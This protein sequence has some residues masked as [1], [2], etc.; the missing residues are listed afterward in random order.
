[1][2]E[3]MV[4]FT[5]AERFPCRLKFGLFFLRFVPMLVVTFLLMFMLVLLLIH[6]I[7]LGRPLPLVL[8]LVAALAAVLIALMKRRFDRTW[9]VAELELSAAGVAVVRPQSRVD[10]SWNGI[11]RLGKADL[12]RPRYLS[13]GSLG[14]KLVTWLVV[15]TIRRP[16]QAALIGAGPG[17]GYA[18]TAIVLPIYE[19]SWEN[20]RIGGWIRAY[21]PDLLPSYPPPAR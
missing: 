12:V 16:A 3:P 10:L 19:Q 15:S 6:A 21:R 20:G 9:G 18:P 2:T 7:G 5:T 13:V 11:R 8:V 1:M 14:A 17:T 4:G